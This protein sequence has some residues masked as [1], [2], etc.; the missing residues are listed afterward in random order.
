MGMKRVR[1][2]VAGCGFFLGAGAAQGGETALSAGNA[3]VTEGDAGSVTLQIPIARTGDLGK[4]VN[5]QVQT[6]PGTTHPA[7]EGADYHPLPAGTRIV[8]PAGQAS[9]F[10]PVTVLGDT[11]HEPDEEFLLHLLDAYQVLPIGFPTSAPY[12]T[13]APLEV[14]TGDLDGDGRHD[15]AVI[16]AALRTITLFRSVG[17]GGI[18]FAAPTTLTVSTAFQPTDFA[19]GDIDGD[20]KLDIV[21]TLAENGDV[22]RTF[23]NTST[24]GTIS[25]A[26]PV[27]AATADNPQ[28]LVIRDLDGNG[29]AD[30]AAVTASGS[31]SVL[32]NLSTA[33][34][35]SFAT[36][37]DL[38]A[39]TDPSSVVA[40]D[41][42]GDGK[43]DLAVINS[44]NTVTTLRN[45]STSGSISFAAGT[46]ASLP[47]APGPPQS[48][49]VGEL[50]GDGKLD[51][52]VVPGSQALAMLRNTSTSG[53]ISFAA[54][55]SVSAVPSPGQAGLAD[56]D[57]DGKQEIVV[58][59]ANPYTTVSIYRN[60]STAGT[61]SFAEGRRFV[62]GRNPVFLALADLDNDGLIDVTVSNTSGNSIVPLR[63]QSVSG[64]LDFL[65]PSVVP[66]GFNAP[67]AHAV[68]VDL[69][70]DGVLDVAGVGSSN[71]P[72]A[73]A[74]RNTAANGRISLAA[75]QCIS[76]GASADPAHVAYG[77]LNGDGKPDLAVAKRGHT[78][79]SLVRNTS[80]PGNLTL[81]SNVALATGTTPSAVAIGDL[82]GDGK[83]DLAV[84]NAGAGTVSVLLNLTT[85][86]ATVFSFA[87]KQD[88]AV[89]TTPVWVAITDQDGDGK[90]DIVA[91]NSG[92]ASMSV[93]RNTSI[94]GTL[95]FA[96]KVDVATGTTPRG[97]VARDLDGDGKPDLAVAN[98]GAASVSV[99]R[100]TSTSGALSY[101]AKVDLATGAAPLAVSAG[102][103]DGDG[104]FDLVSANSTDDTVS[105]LRNTSSG[106]TLSF[107]AKTD[108]LVNDVPRAAEVGDFD[109]NGTPDIMAVTGADHLLTS[110]VFLR[111]ERLAATITDNEGVGTILNDDEAPD[112]V[113]DAFVFTDQVGVPVSSVRESNVVTISG[114]NTSAAVTVSGGEWRKNG[115]SYGASAGTV[116]AGDTVQVRHTSS[117]SNA[118][119][120]HTTLTVGGVADTFTSTTAP[121][122]A[123]IVPDAFSFIDQADVPVSSVRESNVITVSGIDT[124]VTVAVVGGEYRKNG[125]SYGAGASTVVN[126]DTLQVRHV[127][128]ALNAA[129]THTTLSVGDVSDVFTSTTV[130]AVPASAGDGGGGG[131][132]GGGLLLALAW[133]LRRRG[134]AAGRCRA[135]MAS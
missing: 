116:I 37:V 112:A 127:A 10:V 72:S 93:L 3:Q 67:L 130:A 119:A 39:G 82:D 65:A 81:A 75:P 52:V 61:L 29:K 35:I 68:A 104:R 106:G 89:G 103:V 122:G 13:T 126:G 128:S 98:S 66:P 95:G 42:D 85:D 102:D 54:A 118:T 64:T 63:N 124:S 96:T 30:V 25:F 115:G 33:G 18:D 92:S 26:A 16:N 121:A 49:T 84:A 87:T 22:V 135:L 51:L 41:L 19:L 38:A 4:A 77:D 90:A 40:G 8:L 7:T 27:D 97:L 53:A 105:V 20:G 80:T 14:A 5:L 48:L 71:S 134:P 28:N 46:A 17:T 108:V 15:V 11:V 83:P 62:T 2:A 86:N 23:R 9:A 94:G 1:L 69:D 101:A 129:A 110:Y 78:E 100:N 132:F 73:C 111:S 91:A 131:A 6:N 123:D 60:L 36:K 117:A 109:G 114:M 56:M 31:I 99:L 133:A 59:N 12:A 50:D 113:P 21:T 57:G 125:G 58:T 34:T 55:V 76:L 47:A 74:R 120:T 32:R 44:T 88:F 79:V 24:P 43:P 45:L 70:G 107:A